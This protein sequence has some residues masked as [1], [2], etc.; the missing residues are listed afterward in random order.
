MNNGDYT[1]NCTGTAAGTYLFGMLLVK[2]CTST[3]EKA[4]F[5]CVTVMLTVSTSI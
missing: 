2:E 3:S 4:K 5:Y 1:R